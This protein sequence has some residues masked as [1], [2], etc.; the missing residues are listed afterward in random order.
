MKH[1]LLYPCHLTTLHSVHVRFAPIVVKK[2]KVSLDFSLG[3]QAF[4]GIIKMQILN[5]KIK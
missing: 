5:I 3:S 1:T 2:T 4:S